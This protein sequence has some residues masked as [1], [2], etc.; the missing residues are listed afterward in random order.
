VSDRASLLLALARRRPRWWARRGPVTDPW[1]DDSTDLGAPRL[2]RR[3]GLLERFGRA[4]GLFE[5]ERR[6]QEAAA[7][8]L[9]QYR[10]IRAPGEPG[11]FGLAD[12]ITPIPR[13]ARTIT[14]EFQRDAL[15][16]E[17]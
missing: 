9:P 8:R 11:Y 15:E 17:R 1:Y 16:S 5:H 10:P 3:D 13:Y 2:L 6:A 7:R 12:T 14:S 4:R